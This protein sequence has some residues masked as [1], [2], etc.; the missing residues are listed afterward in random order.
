M[1]L[2]SR[3]LSVVL[4]LACFVALIA[5]PAALAKGPNKPTI[6]CV[7]NGT[8]VTEVRQESLFEIRGTNFR[9]YMTVHVCIDDQRCLHSSVDG[10]GKFTQTR[11]LDDP[12]VHTITVEQ[13]RNRKLNSWVLVAT[14][15]INATQ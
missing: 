8:E 3:N 15:T 2:R 14:A 4:A 10:D 6:E 12:G 5:V 13:S 11:Y 1:L 9:P 7:Q